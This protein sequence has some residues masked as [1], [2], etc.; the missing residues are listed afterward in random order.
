MASSIGTA[1]ISIIPTSQNFG[2]NIN[3]L[4]N[5]ADVKS[6]T[7]TGGKAIGSK[8]MSG[9]TTAFKVGASAIGVALAA[10]I[11]S[12]I[13]RLDVLN[14][15]PKVM[16]NMKIPVEQSEK[17][18]N[19]LDKSL[20]G[21]PTPLDK[22]ASAVQRFTSKN[23]DVNKS[24]NIFKAVNNA[25]LAGG[26]PME[27]QT[28]ALEQL[29]Q[30][31]SKGKP[32]M[33]EWR[34]MQSAMPAQLN[35]VAEVMGLGKNS[36]DKLGEGLRNG[37]IDMDDFIKSL[38]NLDKK[39][40]KGFPALKEQA[41][42]AT[43]GVGTQF[44]N[45]KTSLTRTMAEI[46]KAVQEAG[47]FD[48]LQ[49]GVKLLE[50]GIKGLMPIFSGLLSIAT[51]PVF[52]IFAGILTGIAVAFKVATAAIT[53]YKTAVMIATAVTTI[54]NVVLSLNP[55]VLIVLAIAALVAA[56]VVLQVKF[57]IFGKFFNILKVVGVA[58]FNA[59]KTAVL[60]LWHNALLP[61]FNFIK[62][63][64][65]PILKVLAIPVLLAV[66]L[67]GIAIKGLLHIFKTIFNAIKHVVITVFNAIKTPV[68]VV[69]NFYKST[70]TKIFNIIKAIFD[71]VVGAIKN[72]F[73]KIKS[74]ATTVVDA[75]KKP[76][77]GIFNFFK[78]IGSQIWAGLK[79]GLGNIASGL[80]KVFG[81]AWGLVKKVFGIHS[82][83]V[84]F[85][86]LGE[87]MMV[88]LT[89]GIRA[90]LPSVLTELNKIN[91]VD[92]SADYSNLRANTQNTSGI[93]KISDQIITNRQNN[94]GANIPPE[95]TLLDK[96]GS[97]IAKTKTLIQ[98]NNINNYKLGAVI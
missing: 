88:G 22:G 41:R 39:G 90:E 59:I 54:W 44:T 77:S 73:S 64:I 84:K 36:A 20:R 30:A 49:S 38:I 51:S 7:I 57:N 81:A 48:K 94:L 23:A 6:A 37:T 58:V 9:L 68:L 12:A 82:P 2:S 21:L 4:F 18:I 47:I 83:S 61:L 85:M 29:L 15:F 60:F 43:G 92:L 74:L 25:I 31:Y 14:N 42:N 62:A 17:A 1:K 40:Q 19:E 87:M 55:I 8:V 28:Y 72:A 45:L 95:I 71:K 66:A 76:F 80:S 11:P 32:D 79:A 98:K 52:L 89:K 27:I 5:G 3:K 56:L 96:D 78:G 16:Q 93:A 69:F 67:I 97:I 46:I 86:W 91:E 50:A 10:T 24:V 63:V 70:F 65:I 33:M 34:S 35:Q 13:N 53:L 26:A 75:I